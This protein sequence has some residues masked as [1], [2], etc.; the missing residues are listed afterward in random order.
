MSDRGRGDRDDRGWGL[1]PGDEIDPTLVVLEPLG[2]G[3]RY[4][5]FRA[6]DRELFCQ[7]A[8]K[9]VRPARVTHD[10]TIT[11]LDRESSI[12]AR[13]SH[14]NLV[15]FLRRR[16]DGERPHLVLEL[17]TA[18][19]VA[20]HLRDI[21]PVSIPE[22]CLLGIRMLSAL[23]YMHGQHVL[24]LDVKPSNL[25]M[26]APPRLLDLSIA[27]PFAGPLRLREPI[28]TAAYMAPE[29]CLPGEDVTAAADVYGLAATM[30]EALT[31]MQP[32]SDGADQGAAPEERYPQLTEDPLPLEDALGAVPRGLSQVLAAAL[33]RDPA[34]RPGT[35]DAA[36]ALQGV[37]EELGL[38]ELYAW[39]K[40]TKVRPPS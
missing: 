6:W 2:G 30:Y 29:Q 24:H 18:Q 40:G 1:R 15:R 19:T 8:V 3:D 4:E 20:D 27:R 34:R 13:L 26:G 37:L 28:G 31:G 32:F 11:A 7:V 25:T 10:R 38:T 23:H 22:M 35:L 36:V 5:V 21:G 33:A 16:I 9:V 14:P 12:A 17:I 39:P